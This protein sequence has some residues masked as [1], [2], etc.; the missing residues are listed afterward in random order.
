MAPSTGAL[1]L[2][3]GRAS[4]F[5]LCGVVPGVAVATGVGLAVASG[6]IVGVGVL[7]PVSVSSPD[8]LDC[9]TC[10]SDGAGSAS[11]PGNAVTATATPTTSRQRASTI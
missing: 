5:T 9:T 4:V 10:P 3:A 1:P 7:R 2:R 11:F 8:W 6:F